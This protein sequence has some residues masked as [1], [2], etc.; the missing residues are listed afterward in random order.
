MLAID[1]ERFRA[2]ARC[3]AVDL[4]RVYGCSS[5][6]GSV[7]GHAATPEQRSGWLSLQRKVAEILGRSWKSSTREQTER[8]SAPDD[9]QLTGYE[10]FWL[11]AELLEALRAALEAAFANRGWEQWGRRDQ[12]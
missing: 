12:K 3:R 8:C 4:P 10:A 6:S 7:T 5:V 11:K 9:L 1:R 2:H